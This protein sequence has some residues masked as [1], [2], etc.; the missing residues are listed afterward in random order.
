MITNI[1][2]ALRYIFVDSRS[3]HF[4][5]RARISQVWLNRWI[6][7]LLLVFA[8]ILFLVDY[9]VRDIGLVKYSLSNVNVW[10]ANLIVGLCCFS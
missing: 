4:R 7:L 9:L 8:R 10:P 2:T 1:L 3:L 5:Y 6:I